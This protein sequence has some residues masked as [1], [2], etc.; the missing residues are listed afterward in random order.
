MQWHAYGDRQYMRSKYLLVRSA[1]PSDSWA[2]VFTVN[3]LCTLLSFLL[4]TP[5][6]LVSCVQAYSLCAVL[7]TY[8]FAICAR[9]QYHVWDQFVV[10]LCSEWSDMSSSVRRLPRRRH[11]DVVIRCGSR[12]S[13]FLPLYSL[14]TITNTW[15]AHR[16]KRPRNV[17]RR[18]A[19]FLSACWCLSYAF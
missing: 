18:W 13:L 5:R 10:C 12:S 11:S 7:S 9:V 8:S 17:D 1:S 15:E 14:N 19:D 4:S 2:L 16:R 6:L 3:A